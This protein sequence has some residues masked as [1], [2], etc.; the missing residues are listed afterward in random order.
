MVQRKLLSFLV[1]FVWVGIINSTLLLL[2]AASGVER[3]TLV[4]RDNVEVSN[5]HRQVIHT[6]GR[7]G[8]SKAGSSRDAMRSLNPTVSVTAV[9][10]PL[11]WDNYMELVRGNDCM[12]DASNNPRKQ[13]LINYY[14]ILEEREP[15]M[16]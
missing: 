4:D 16:A 5:F 13:Y 2:L 12:V 14:C 10:H 3:I 9:S 15:K 8:M 7:R 11:T 1:L 6:E